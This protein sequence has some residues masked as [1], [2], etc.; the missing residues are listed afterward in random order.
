MNTYDP[1][2]VA[3][4]RNEKRVNEAQLLTPLLSTQ[5]PTGV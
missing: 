5:S 4:G 2:L 3:L 1:P